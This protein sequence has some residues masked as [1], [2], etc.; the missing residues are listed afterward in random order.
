MNNTMEDVE[1]LKTIQWFFDKNKAVIEH[2]QSTT[3]T[4]QPRRK[5]K[6]K[7]QVLQPPLHSYETVTF[8]GD[9]KS[10]LFTP[11]FDNTVIRP[12]HVAL[13]SYSGED[14]GIWRFLVNSI[15]RT[16]PFDMVS[17][18]IVSGDFN[19]LSIVAS[20]ILADGSVVA[21]ESFTIGAD[22]PQ[23]LT[24][25]PGFKNISK[26]SFSLDASDLGTT[27]PDAVGTTIGFGRRARTH[28]DKDMAITNV[29][30]KYL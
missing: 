21:T 8:D 29:K 16:S 28:F 6:P 7:P 3:V 22:N 4:K 1:I 2:N 26:L 24:F 25:P 15:T 10:L 12:G 27:H 13:R 30:I 11:P 9:L 23:T 19:D 5:P 17:L 14:L 18:D 20:G